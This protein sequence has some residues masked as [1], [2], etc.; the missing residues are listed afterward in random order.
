MPHG[1]T[2]PATLEGVS[3][4][5]LFNATASPLYFAVY[6]PSDAEVNCNVGIKVEDPPTNKAIWWRGHRQRS[7][8]KAELITKCTIYSRRCIFKRYGHMNHNHIQSGHH[9]YDPI[10]MHLPFNKDRKKVE[11]S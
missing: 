6:H 11:Q 9:I 4:P 1:G 3:A 8:N 10:K 2:T 7:A 5:Q